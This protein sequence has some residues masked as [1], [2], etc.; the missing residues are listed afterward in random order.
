MT[1]YAQSFLVRIKQ[2]FTVLIDRINQDRLTTSAASLAYTTILAIV[3]LITVILSLLSV[4]PIFA[5]ISDLF[6][7]FIFDNL[8]PTTGETV[9]QYLEQF[10]SNTQRMT[11]F[12]ILGLVVTSLLLIRSIDKAFNLI[13]KTK[14]KRSLMYNLTM[15]WTVLTLGPILVGFSLAISSYIVSLRLFSQVEIVPDFLRVLPFLISVFG[16]WLLYCI[17]PTEPIPIKES[18]IGACIAALL[19]DVGKRIFT[20][21]VSSFPTYQLIYGVVSTIPILLVWIYFSWCI[22]LLG[23]EFSAALVEYKKK[24]HTP[25]QLSSDMDNV[26]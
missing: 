24:Y 15:Y 9:Q 20:L 22:I 1:Q 3:P 21:Y 19:F 5:D 11:V 23:A 13:W 4:F 6:K 10:V 25:A 12:G 8:A 7:Q 14:R 17:V 16:F 18:I 26:Q 2:F